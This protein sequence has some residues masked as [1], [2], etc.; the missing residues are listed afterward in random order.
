MLQSHT[1]I[2]RHNKKTPV[3]FPK[4]CEY[5]FWTIFLVNLRRAL[6]VFKPL[7]IYFSDMRPQRN[8]FLN[9]LTFNLK[10]L[11]QSKLSL[12][13]LN[14]FISKAIERRHVQP[15]CSLITYLV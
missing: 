3:F 1:N 13:P 10:T 9:T 6:P 7:C 11:M 15:N 14:P 8:Q 4:T 2:M 5:Y 12:A